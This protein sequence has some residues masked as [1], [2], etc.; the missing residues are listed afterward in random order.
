ATGESLGRRRRK[1]LTGGEARAVSD[2]ARRARD[3]DGCARD[4]VDVRTYFERV[5]NALAAELRREA[6]RVDREISVRLVVLDDHDAGEDPLGVHADEDLDGPVVRALERLQLRRPERETELR[7]AAHRLEMRW[8]AGF[9]RERGGGRKQPLQIGFRLGVN[10][11]LC[12][13]YDNGNGGEDHGQRVTHCARLYRY[14]GERPA[15]ERPAPQTS[16]LKGPHC[17]GRP[18]FGS[19]MRRLR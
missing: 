12:R 9:R 16:R 4:G 10:R 14:N 11:R 3:A 5:A 13:E 15:A 7:L 6:R 1:Q 18:F 2:R 17:A 19:P 8:I